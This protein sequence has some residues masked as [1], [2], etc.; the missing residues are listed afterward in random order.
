VHGAIWGREPQR[1]REAG[2]INEENT[3]Q[4]VGKTQGFALADIELRQRGREELGGG[5]CG[6]PFQGKKFHRNGGQVIFTGGAE[7]VMTI[8]NGEKKG[9]KEADGVGEK[10]ASQNCNH[11]Y[12]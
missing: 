5:S 8:K 10:N 1:G 9:Q 3:R 2:K 7:W 12:G 6:N 11:T 4:W